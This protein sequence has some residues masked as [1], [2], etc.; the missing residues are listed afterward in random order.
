MKYNKT[1]FS[2]HNYNNSTEKERKL[3]NFSPLCLSM[4]QNYHL[5]RSKSKMEE[6]PRSNVSIDCNF[7]Y[8]V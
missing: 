1:W 8:L 6:N 4:S 3:I 2:N 5:G 7:F